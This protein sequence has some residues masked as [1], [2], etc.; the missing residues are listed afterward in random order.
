MALPE[1]NGKD[2][3]GDV[4]GLLMVSAGEGKLMKLI[5]AKPENY[6]A[7]IRISVS[8]KVSAGEEA[9]IRVYASPGEVVSGYMKVKIDGRVAKERFTVCRKA[10]L[11]EIEAPVSYGRHILEVDFSGEKSFALLSTPRITATALT[12]EPGKGEG[13]LSSS[14]REKRTTEERPLFS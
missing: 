11:E 3:K 13:W 6:S 10:C 5:P 12:L 14:G 8:E 1:G 7:N 4:R 2:G 9:V